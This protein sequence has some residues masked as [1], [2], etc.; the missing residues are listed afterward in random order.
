MTG[1]M[2]TSIQDI[3]ARWVQIYYALYALRRVSSKKD[4][5]DAVGLRPQNMKPIEDQRRTVPLTIICN[6]L[7][8]YDIRPDWLFLGVGDMISE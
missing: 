4:F 7:N 8:A 5:C 2:K 1:N 6:T 3:S